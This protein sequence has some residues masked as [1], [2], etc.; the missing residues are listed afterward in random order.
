MRESECR[1]NPKVLGSSWSRYDLFVAFEG[2]AQLV[3]VQRLVIEVLQWIGIVHAFAASSGAYMGTMNL[4]RISIIASGSACLDSDD[5]RKKSEEEQP[6]L[7]SH[8]GQNDM[9]GA[10]HD[11]IAPS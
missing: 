7:R 10:A 2:L 11:V 1:S 5:K 6:Y 4:R 9:D 8:L 3:A